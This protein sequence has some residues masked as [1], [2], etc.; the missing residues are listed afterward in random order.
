MCAFA[1]LIDDCVRMLYTKRSSS[2]LVKRNLCNAAPNQINSCFSSSHW[3]GVHL[4]AISLCLCHTLC[5]SSGPGERRRWWQPLGC[6]SRRATK[7]PFVSLLFFLGGWSVG[8]ALLAWLVPLQE[9]I[10]SSVMRLSWL[11]LSCVS[12]RNYRSA[13]HTL[14]IPLLSVGYVCVFGS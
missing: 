5:H 14:W 8:C 2:C 9:L 13:G 3:L 10:Y 6:A 12:M 4:N 7:F 1:W 11:R